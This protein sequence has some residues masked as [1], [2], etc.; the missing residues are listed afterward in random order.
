MKQLARGMADAGFVTIL[1]GENVSEEDAE[2]VAEYIRKNT[3]NGCE[4]SVMYGGQPIY[5]YVVWVE[6]PQ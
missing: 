4:V 3:E 1:Y 2:K 6:Q 5:D